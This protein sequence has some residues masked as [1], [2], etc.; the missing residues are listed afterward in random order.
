MTPPA[1]SHAPGDEAAFGRLFDA[2][3]AEVWR[4][5]RRRCA[6]D[7]DADD[8]AAETFAVAWRRWETVPVDGAHLWLLGVARRV[9]ANQR[10]SL[11]RLGGLRRRLAA[12]GPG[13]FSPDPADALVDGDRRIWRALASLQPEDRDLLI[14]RAWD[15]LA[16]ADMAELL[17]CTPNAVSV[18][19]YK[20]RRRLAD[21]LAR[22]DGTRPGHPAADPV[23]MEGGQP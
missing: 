11:G 16:V 20:A 5:A 15:E 8:V 14:M 23:P 7:H 17:G 10:R 21:G 4:F 13:V 1:G 2:H 3:M 9:L 6:S 22:T 18:R 12:T 19:L